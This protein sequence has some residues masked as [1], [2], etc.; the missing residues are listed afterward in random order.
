VR[1]GGA[2]TRIGRIVL[3]LAL[4]GCAMTSAY[5]D[6]L[7]QLD[8][9]VQPQD[10]AYASLRRQVVIAMEEK[11]LPLSEVLTGLETSA[12]LR[13]TPGGSL[14]SED[15]TFLIRNG[16]LGLYGGTAFSPARFAALRACMAERYGMTI[17]V[18]EIRSP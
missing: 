10:Q 17:R 5:S 4:S 2:G 14:S 8:A 18:I 9:C 6:Q 16:F 3:A 7:A 13:V 11:G 12:R 15:S 1:T